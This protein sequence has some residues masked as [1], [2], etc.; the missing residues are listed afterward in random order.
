M[1]DPCVITSPYKLRSL[2]HISTRGLHTVILHFPLTLRWC[3]TLVTVF[4]SSAPTSRTGGTLGRLRGIGSQRLRIKRSLCTAAPFSHNDHVRPNAFCRS[5][6]SSIKNFNYSRKALS[7]LYV[8]SHHRNRSPRR[9]RNS[10]VKPVPST[11]TWIT[12]GQETYGWNGC[13][14]F[15]W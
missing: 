13:L 10:C 8:L 7:R 12:H 6:S 14:I 15:D 1:Y 5:R 2:Y 11:P 4:S 9:R 3:H